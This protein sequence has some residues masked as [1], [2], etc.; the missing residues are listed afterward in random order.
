MRWSLSE[1]GENGTH[2]L[3][4]NKKNSTAFTHRFLVVMYGD[5]PDGVGG[6]ERRG[7][8]VLRRDLRRHG[9][10]GRDLCLAVSVHLLF[11]FSDI[12]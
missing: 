8:D 10:D 12:V 2:S 4:I 5:G 11:F 1:R 6:G 7:G 9:G 3:R